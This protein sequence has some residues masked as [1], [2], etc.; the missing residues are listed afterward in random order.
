M[1]SLL[2]ILLFLGLINSSSQY[3]TSQLHQYESA[4]S[5]VITT[6]ES[7]QLQMENVSRQYGEQSTH[8]VVLNDEENP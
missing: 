8:I 3:T 1:L 4:N 2:Q 5:I 7:D 6:I